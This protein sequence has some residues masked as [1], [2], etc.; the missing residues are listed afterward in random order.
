MPDVEEVLLEVDER[1]DKSVK[2]LVTD[3]GVIRTGRANP[4]LVETLTVDYYNEPAMLNQLASISVPEPRVILI[5]PWDKQSIVAM[6]KSIL[7]SNLGLV[8][9]NDGTVI[10]I[11]IPHLTEERRRE[12][13]QLVNKR[14]EEGIVAVRNI[15]R[16]GLETIRSMQKNRE[17]SQDEMRRAQDDLQEITD[18]Y[19]SQMQALGKQKEDEVMEV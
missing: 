7:A 2:A 8:P 13:V 12:L 10:R 3:L 4:S 18:G 1:M 14:V 9:V 15:R 5:R 11:T 6:E 19:T 16:D 17:L